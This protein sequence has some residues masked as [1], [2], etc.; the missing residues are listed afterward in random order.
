MVLL[1]TAILAIGWKRVFP[2]NG[3]LAIILF[4][5]Y[6]EVFFI[7]FTRGWIGFMGVFGLAIAVIIALIMMVSYVTYLR[8]Y[9][10][11]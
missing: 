4:G 11:P 8:F 3:P 7:F 2:F 5:F 10:L 9:N 6:F 1:F